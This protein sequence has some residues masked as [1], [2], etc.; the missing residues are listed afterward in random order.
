MNLNFSNNKYLR[1]LYA[2]FSGFYPKK[3]WRR[4]DI[5]LDKE[6]KMIKRLFCLFYIKRID[7]K[8]HCSFGTNLNSNTKFMKPPSLVH[9][10]SGIIIGYNAHFGKNV[11]IAPGVIVL[12][13]ESTTII[14]DNVFLGAGC[15]I[16]SG[17]RIGHDSKI[18]ANAVVTEDI[19]PHSTVVPQK[20]RI[21]VHSNVVTSDNI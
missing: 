3:Y 10:P 12:H 17:V 1:K 16:L 2:F 11:H 9:G 15:K 18:G 6:E 7:A 14:E 19:P 21:I 20:S 5:V 13:G 4:R 8:L